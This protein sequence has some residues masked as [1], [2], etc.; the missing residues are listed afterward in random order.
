[1]YKDADSGIGLRNKVLTNV[2]RFVVVLTFNNFLNLQ[3]LS[4]RSAWIFAARR[5]F[6][7]KS[8]CI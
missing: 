6:W 4:K 7:L 5:V 8:N 1:M 2:L 3:I